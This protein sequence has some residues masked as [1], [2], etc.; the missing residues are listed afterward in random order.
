[1]RT[2]ALDALRPRMPGDH[3][4]IAIKHQDHLAVHEQ[5]R[6]IVAVPLDVR[7]IVNAG[8]R[9]DYSPERRPR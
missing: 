6:Q 5:A 8:H 9:S 1:M 4:P 2:V 7:A 3:P